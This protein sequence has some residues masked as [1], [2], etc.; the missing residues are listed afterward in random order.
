MF[1]VTTTNEVGTPC[2]KEYKIVYI[3]GIPL[4]QCISTTIHSQDIPF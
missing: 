1:T 2:T 4:I 3:L